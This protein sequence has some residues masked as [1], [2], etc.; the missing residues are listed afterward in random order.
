MTDPYIKD[1][2]A[3]NEKISQKFSDLEYEMDELKEKYS[4]QVEFASIV[5]SECLY[6]LK[7]LASLEYS[8]RKFLQENNLYEDV[9]F[10]SSFGE[11]YIRD[12]LKSLVEESN[13]KLSILGSLS[14]FKHDDIIEEFINK[15][16]VTDKDI[17][18]EN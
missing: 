14:P 16:G 10:T 3:A 1:L 17:E 7:S 8:Y 11:V 6:N 18:D 5:L 9:T 2:E 15:F 13:G 4:K 12:F